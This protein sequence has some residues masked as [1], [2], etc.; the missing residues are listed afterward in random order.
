MLVILITEFIG[1]LS[2][3]TPVGSASFTPPRSQPQ[4]KFLP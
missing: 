4:T 2:H 1:A 3:F